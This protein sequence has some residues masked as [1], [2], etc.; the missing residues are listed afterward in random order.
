MSVNGAGQQVNVTVAAGNPAAG[1]P[2]PSFELMFAPL[3]IGV[4]L[5]AMLFGVFIVLV[6]SYFR[7]YKT[8]YGWIRY[9]IYYLI[10]LEVI[11]TVCDIGLIYEPL[12]TLHNSTSVLM[13]SPKLLAADP[14][15]TTLISTPTQLFMAWRIRRVTRSNWL[16]GSVALLAFASFVGGLV[17]TI[18][19]ATHPKFAQFVLAEAPLTLWLTSTA[20]ADLFITVF[21]V[22]FLWKNKT[23][24]KTQTDSVTDRIILFTVQTGMLTSVA[25]IA[26]VSLFLI[27]PRTTFMFIWDFSLS[28]LYS[29]CLIATLNARHEWNDLLEESP[30]ASLEKTLSKDGK[31]NPNAI[32]KLR[33]AADVHNLQLYIPSQFQAS[34]TSATSPNVLSPGARRRTPTARHAYRGENGSLDSQGWIP[35]PMPTVMPGRSHVS[36]KQSSSRSAKAKKTGSG[37][38][39]AG[40]DMLFGQGQEVSNTS[41]DE[42]LKPLLLAP[43]ARGRGHAHSHS[44]SSSSAESAKRTAEWAMV[45]GR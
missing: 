13:D 42:S 32:I 26:D 16:S 31:P 40:R 6:H 3:L 41:G 2:P 30:A 12:I 23:G 10:L 45:T 27:M 22:N 20:F 1:P 35:R 36:T 37:H 38:R 17:A 9:L 8:D 33:A 19:V 15:V 24:F 43:N 7:L 39:I 4:V 14:V 44:K 28:K 5:N 29:I 21:L 11:N 25:A 34:R 18:S